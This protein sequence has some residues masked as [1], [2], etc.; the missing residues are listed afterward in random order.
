MFIVKVNLFFP[1]SFCA[2]LQ[3][4]FAKSGLNFNGDLMVLAKSLPSGV[5]AVP[6]PVKLFDGSEPSFKTE[7]TYPFLFIA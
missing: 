4:F 7:L 5:S 3:F 1:N 6:I 2:S